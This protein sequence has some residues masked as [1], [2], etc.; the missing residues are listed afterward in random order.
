[1]PGLFITGTDTGIGKTTVACALLCV[2]KD[3]QLTTAVMKPVASGCNGTTDGLRSDDAV[4]LMQFATY[5]ADYREVNPYAFA[6]AIAPQLAAAEQ[7]VTINLE[8]LVSGA[9]ALEQQVDIL[10]V[11]GIG[12]WRVPLNEHQGTEDLAAA[13]NYPVIMVVGMRLGCINHA[14]LTAAAIEASGL[15]LAGWLANGIEP[16]LEGAQETFI[17]LKERLAT[18]CLGVLPYLAQPHPAESPTEYSHFLNNNII[19]SVVDNI[20]ST[21][22]AGQ[23]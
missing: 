10:L 1:M 17:T 8:Q 18:P 22:A 16:E 15:T 2:L 20:C 19:Q 11:E 7:G 12:G 5:T 23:I 6:H 9:R 21:P 4:R 14:L 3:M 13:L